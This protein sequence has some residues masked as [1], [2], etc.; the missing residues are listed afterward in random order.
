M[1]LRRLSI[2]PLLGVTALLGAV[3]LADASGAARP[4]PPPGLAV[5]A[6]G[7]LPHVCGTADGKFGA[8]GDAPVSGVYYSQTGNGWAS[9]PLCYPL[10]GNLAMSG[11]TIAKGGSRVTVTAIPNQGSNSATWA[12]VKPGAV[13]WQPAGTPEKG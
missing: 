7:A 5:V 9:A 3:L 13:Q 6:A 11:P 4:P 12:I 2:V 10:W 1:R 8:T